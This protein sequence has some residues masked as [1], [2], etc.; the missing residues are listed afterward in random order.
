MAKTSQYR[1]YYLGIDPNGGVQRVSEYF[2]SGGVKLSLMT[3]DAVL[4]D[5]HVMNG[6]QAKSEVV[7]VYG[8]RDVEFVSVAMEDSELEKRIAARVEEKAKKLAT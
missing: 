1:G 6:R 5:H 4:I 2:E 7:I 8:L 3:D